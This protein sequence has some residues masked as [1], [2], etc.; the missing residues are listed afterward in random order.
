MCKCLSTCDLFSIRSGGVLPAP[1]VPPVVSPQPFDAPLL[2][3]LLR[4]PQQ[5]WADKRKGR[6]GTEAW[7]RG[8][9]RR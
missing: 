2:A 6:G 7:D 1:E 9:G 4:A 3:L 8:A 5:L